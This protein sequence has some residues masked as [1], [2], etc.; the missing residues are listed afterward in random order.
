MVS[1]S[2]T[3]WKTKDPQT[4]TRF[5]GAGVLPQT[6]F[7]PGAKLITSIGSQPVERL[8]SGM[9]VLTFDG[10]FQH[11]TQVE[12]IILNAG[13]SV[14][15]VP[16]GVIGN[17]DEIQLPH[18]QGLMFDAE[19]SQEAFVEPFS[20]ITASQ[21]DGHWGIKRET[22]DEPTVLTRIHFAQDEVILSTIGAM[23]LCP[24]AILQTAGPRELVA[25]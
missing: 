15:S 14:I 6:G 9:K 12:R 23:F 2:L 22:L 10:G 17:A 3:L 8:S 4:N 24:Q 25:A 19:M 7:L 20:L 11:V 16:K 5:G 1:A 21:M 13:T 18:D